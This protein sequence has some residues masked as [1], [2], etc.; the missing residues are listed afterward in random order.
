MKRSFLWLVLVS[1][2]SLLAQAQPCQTGRLDPRVALALRTVLADLPSSL[3]TSVEQIRDV[4]IKAPAFPKA[5]VAYIKADGI[6]VHVYNPA[7][8]RGLP[9]IISLHPGGFVT[10]ILPFMEYEFWRQAK[11]YQALVFAVDYRVAPEHK[12]PAAVN[13]AYAAFKWIAANGQRYGGDTSRIV[14]LG[15]SA[16]GNL[17]AVVC[18]KANLDGLANR[19]KLQVLNCPSTDN[20]R[21]FAQHPS[22]Q[23]YATG[24]FQTKAFSQYSIRAYAPYVALD[25]PEVAPLHRKDVSGLPPAVI[26]TAEFDPLRDEGYAYAERLRKAGVPVDYVCFGGQIH[27]LLGLPPDAV[28]HRRVDQLILSAMKKNAKKAK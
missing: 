5:D 27:C 28:E 1:F 17:A 7:H 26:I 19:I 13:D 18:Q 8:A 6:P 4:N 9:I 11:T 25:N 3:T 23:Q 12:Y 24:Y 15:S 22:Y 21:N 14:V 16:G 2:S 10:P 20:P